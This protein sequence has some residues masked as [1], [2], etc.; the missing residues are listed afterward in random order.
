MCMNYIYK[1]MI[2]NELKQLNKFSSRKNVMLNAV[3]HLYRIAGQYSNGVVEMLHCVQ[4][5]VLS[6]Y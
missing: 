5:D 6:I 2:I 1:I 4:H 3:K